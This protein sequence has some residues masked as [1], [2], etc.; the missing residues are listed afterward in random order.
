M[1]KSCKAHLPPGTLLVM[2]DKGD[3]ILD[4]IATEAINI[5][6]YARVVS[7]LISQNG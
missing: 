7:T 1:D 5:G 3:R 4:L 2:E 6:I